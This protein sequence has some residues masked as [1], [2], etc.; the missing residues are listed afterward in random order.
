MNA[1]HTD[2]AF[3]YIKNADAILFVTYYNHAFS[4]ADRRFLTQLGG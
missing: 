4:Q 3:H 1:R 2:V